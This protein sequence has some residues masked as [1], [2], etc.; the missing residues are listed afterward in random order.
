MTR[1]PATAS[2]NEEAPESVAR[3]AST[4][5]TEF[6]G[7]ELVDPSARERKTGEKSGHGLACE[8]AHQQVHA[9][10]GQH[11]RREEQSVIAKDD[12]V[13]CRKYRQ[14]L[15]HLRSEMLGIGQRQRRRVEDVAIPIAKQ[16]RPIAVEGLKDLT[17]GPEQNPADE[18]GIARVS[19]DLPGHDRHKWP[20][21][22]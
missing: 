20:R 17:A 3:T 13:G 18:E 11:D 14:R 19:R 22:R 7:G 16:R 5:S 1:R 21:R 10:A 9:Q 6:A 12:V 8:L 2:C 4:G 15:Q